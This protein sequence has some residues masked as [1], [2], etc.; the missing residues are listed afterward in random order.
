MFQS[1]PVQPPHSVFRESH[2][3]RLPDRGCPS[4]TESAVEPPLDQPPSYRR[5]EP[6]R[7]LLRYGAAGETAHWSVPDEGLAER[8]SAPCLMVRQS[9]G[10]DLTAPSRVTRRPVRWRTAPA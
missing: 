8:F 1:D 3:C 7:C 4:I 5:S 6:R 10:A 2:C 9:V